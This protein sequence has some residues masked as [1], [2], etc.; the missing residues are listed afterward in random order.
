MSQ[1]ANLGI[2][3]GLPLVLALVTTIGLTSSGAAEET[4][5]FRLLQLTGSSVKWGTPTMG[6]GATV[7]YAFLEAPLNFPQARNCRAM[8]GIEALLVKS[9]IDR[10]DFEA[11]TAAA[12][13]A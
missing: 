8:A 4:T 10:V 1:K 3:R 2:I 6:T 5:T 11:E 9:G 12:F 7:T 13:Q